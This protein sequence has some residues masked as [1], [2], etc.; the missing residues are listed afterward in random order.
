MEETLKLKAPL[1]V[2]FYEHIGEN[3]KGRLAYAS[4]TV[5]VIPSLPLVCILNTILKKNLT[6]L[7][8]NLNVF[9]W[10]CKAL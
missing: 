3:F 4:T 8:L 9:L 10:P 5:P 1:S 2:N 6:F 7:N